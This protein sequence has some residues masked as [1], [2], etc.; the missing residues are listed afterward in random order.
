MF[1]DTLNTLT[2]ISFVLLGTHFFVESSSAALQLP[3]HL[4]RLNRMD[5]N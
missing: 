5:N 1:L 2:L 3:L 4:S